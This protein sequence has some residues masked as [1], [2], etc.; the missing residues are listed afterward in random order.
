MNLIDVHHT[1]VKQWVK[2]STD[3]L[4]SIAETAASAAGLASAKWTPRVVRGENGLEVRLEG[5]LGAAYAGRSARIAIGKYASTWGGSRV[6]I[7]NENGR[8][9]AS[10]TV[11]VEGVAPA[12][13]WADT[14]PAAAVVSTMEPRRPATTADQ[15]GPGVG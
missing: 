6:E 13:V 12:R 3:A 7:T 1:T 9:V 14:G 4:A 15:L 11:L 8:L 5:Q 10:T 2:Y